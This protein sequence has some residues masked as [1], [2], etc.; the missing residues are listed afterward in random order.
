M[1]S[2]LFREAYV[3]FSVELHLKDLHVILTGKAPRIHNIH[4]LFEKL[5]PSIK[6]EILAHESISKNPFM[7]SG[8][9]FSSQYFSQT[10]TLNDRFLDQMKAIS[11][12]FEKWRYAH[13][14]VTLKYDSF[15]AI[16]LIE[17][18]AST[19][20]NIRQQNYKKM[21]R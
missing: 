1:N 7:T 19:A 2:S 21:K 15:F 11:D 13:E 20:D 17:A 14:S 10:Y 8:D 5:P 18:V 4:K 6:Q 9:I 3:A 12:G 16:G